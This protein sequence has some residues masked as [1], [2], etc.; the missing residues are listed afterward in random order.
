MR[1]PKCCQLNNGLAIYAA[2]LSVM[3]SLMHVTLINTVRA[4][5]PEEAALQ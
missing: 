5:R 1:Q 3:R 4:S 2:T